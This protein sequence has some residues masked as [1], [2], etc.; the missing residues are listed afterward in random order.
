MLT[1]L[2]LFLKSAPEPDAA[3]TIAKVAERT[4]WFTFDQK[5]VYV[6]M[7]ECRVFTK[8]YWLYWNGSSWS[9][10]NNMKS[11][12]QK[13]YMG[14]DTVKTGLKGGTWF[15]NLRW[16]GLLKNPNMPG[17]QQVDSSK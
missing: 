15:A 8:Y 7:Y 4:P 9:K 12:I 3:Q 13:K 6:G 10:P 5:P 11:I 17:N 1:L 14:R 2:N 16:R